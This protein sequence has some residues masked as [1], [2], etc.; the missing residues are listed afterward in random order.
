VSTPHIVLLGDSIF[1]NAAYVAG[2]PDVVE[3]LRQKLPPGWRATLRAVDGAV[4]TAV[5]RQLEEVPRDASHLVLSVGGNDALSHIDLLDRPARSF[6]EVLEALATV[7]EEFEHRYVRTVDAVLGL[8][9]PLVICT[10]YD[11][12]LEDP[13]RRRSARAALTVFNDVILRCASAR[14]LPVIELRQVCTEPG[15]Y[16][17]PIE[18]SVQGGRKIA[19]AVLKAIEEETRR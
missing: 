11:G 17:N 1:D 14:R 8:C 4:A 9:L 15:D 7:G 18:P 6:T 10:I 12:N 19:D 5:P 16:A 13:R 2:G 3:Q